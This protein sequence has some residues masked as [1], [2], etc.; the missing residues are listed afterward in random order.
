MTRSPRS[1]SPESTGWPSSPDTEGELHQG[2]ECLGVELRGAVDLL[3]VQQVHQ[4]AE[5]AVGHQD[6]SDEGDE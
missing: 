6:R 1:T 4:A 3:E 2:E 5:N